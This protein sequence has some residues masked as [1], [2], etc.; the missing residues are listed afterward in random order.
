MA[1][2]FG[3]RGRSIPCLTFC[4]ADSEAIAAN[5]CSGCTFSVQPNLNR[6]PCSARPRCQNLAD[7]CCFRVRTSGSLGFK[8]GAEEAS[9]PLVNLNYQ[10]LFLIRHM[11]P[12]QQA[13]A[14]EACANLIFT[15]RF[16]KKKGRIAPFLP[17]TFVTNVAQG[18]Q[19]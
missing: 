8:V 18:A 13:R 17:L 10:F 2:N 4:A 7:N 6:L 9:K 11:P 12:M 1:F 16:S 5:C 3:G 14:S 15:Y 19:K